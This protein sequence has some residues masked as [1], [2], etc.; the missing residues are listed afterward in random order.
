MAGEARQPDE[1]LVRSLALRGPDP[2]GREAGYRRSLVLPRLIQQLLE[3]LVGEVLHR[4]PAVVEGSGAMDVAVDLPPKVDV[5]RW[6]R[7]ARLRSGRHTH[8]WLPGDP[9]LPPL[10][11]PGI[12]PAA[13]HG[14]PV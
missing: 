10:P 8:P 4:T 3:L 11:I 14:Q 7:S 9:D 2:K 12:G 1:S 13:D 6:H 5:A